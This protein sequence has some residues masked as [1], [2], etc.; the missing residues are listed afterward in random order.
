M[1]HLPVLTPGK[2]TKVLIV[3]DVSSS[4][5]SGVNS[6]NDYLHRGPIILPDLCGLLL[7]F[8]LYPIIVLADV[9]NVFLQVG[10]QERERDTTRFLWLKDIT[11]LDIE[12]NLVVYRYCCVPFGLVCNPFLLGATI[13]FHL[14]RERSPLVLH[15]L[16]STWIML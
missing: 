8:R 9:R 2:T 12:S 13:K 11:K 14:Q 10:L 4:V 1:P 15:I 6:L 7:R 3:F 16:I 5:R